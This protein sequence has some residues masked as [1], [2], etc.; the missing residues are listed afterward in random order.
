M[1]ILVSD[2]KA[3]VQAKGYGTDTTAQQTAFLQEALRRLYGM[4]RWRF[5]LAYDSSLSLPLGG[6]TVV[7]SGLAGWN[8]KVEAVRL[9]DATGNTWELKQRAIEDV[10]KLDGADSSNDTPQYWALRDNNTF[11]FWPRA[12]VPYTLLVDYIKMP[13]L[14]VNDTDPITW[15]DDHMQ[16]LTWAVVKGMAFRQRDWF[17]TPTADQEYQ[18]ALDEMEQAHGMNSSQSPAEVGHWNGWFTVAR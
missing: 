2:V 11:Q 10:R 9:Q 7:A 17:T 8:G 3:A 16:V 5:L 18:T 1:S 15:P 6:S 14:P 4:R 13:T 12:D